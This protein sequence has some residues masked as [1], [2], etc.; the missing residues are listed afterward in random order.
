MAQ[1]QP[2]AGGGPGGNQ[3]PSPFSTIEALPDLGV[4]IIRSQ[5]PEQ[6]A[7]MRKL[8]ETL[9]A[10]TEPSNIEVGVRAAALRRRDQHHDNADRP[11]PAR[12]I[13][14]ATGNSINQRATTSINAATPGGGAFS[15]NNQQPASVVLLAVPRFNSIFVAAPKGRLPE[16][17]KRIEE[18][19]Q[20]PSPQMQ[21][22]PFPLT[23]A[24]AARVA[25]LINNFW[26]T[27]YPPETQ[28]QNQ[29]RVTYDD[30]TNTVFVQAGP[31]DLKEIADLISRLDTT[32][33]SAIDELRIFQLHNALADEL[34]NLLVR[35][36]SA[37]IVAPSST[38]S[39]LPPQVTGG[40]A[41]AG[42][43]LGGGALGGRGG[44]GGGALA[45]A[46][47]WSALGGGAFGGGRSAAVPWGRAAP[48]LPARMRTRSRR[49][50]QDGHLAVLPAGSGRPHR[51]GRN[52]RRHPHHS[53]HADQHPRHRRPQGGDEA[54]GGLDRE[55]GHRPVH[56]FGHQDHHAQ[57]ERCVEYG[58]SA[59]TALPELGRY[60]HW[61]RRP[62]VG[63]AAA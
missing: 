10:I 38:T 43:A 47:G 61:R 1:G 15:L 34:S 24:S 42:G 28:T 49:G 7:L 60:H 16:I 58:D 3:G 8:I 26:A 29:I 4:L 40:A 19:D 32:V 52:A 53:R 9:L 20:P 14:G 59:A 17:R 18:L 25:V 63:Q 36:I 33:S 22:A 45:A 54:A 50:H 37:G 41:G 6:A 12:L 27:R 2:P 46:P 30:S 11:V 44:A 21:A 51:R 35:A 55:A 39:T 13:V 62:A 5:N 23:K 48:V 57:E 56:A 31:A